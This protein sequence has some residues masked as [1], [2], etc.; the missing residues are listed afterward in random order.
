MSRSISS[1][2]A[3]IAAR[4]ERLAATIDE[5][6]ERATPQAILARQT[7]S[8]KARFTAATTHDDGS[9]KVE[10]VAALAVVALAVVAI[11]VWRRRRG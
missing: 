8:A 11:A 4:R 2:E 6:A 10:Q 7:E 9:V 5:L 1:L 3:D